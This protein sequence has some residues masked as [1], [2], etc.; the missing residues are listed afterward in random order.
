MVHSL[1]TRLLA[2]TFENEV[3]V[4]FPLGGR[5]AAL[6][7]RPRPSPAWGRGWS[8]VRVVARE[9]ERQR[10]AGLR[11]GAPGA[12]GSQDSPRAH[13]P[14]TVV[15]VVVIII[16]AA[17]VIAIASDERIG[18]GEKGVVEGGVCGDPPRRV[19]REEAA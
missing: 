19:A 15:A 18:A 7:A 3:E 4:A 16:V 17:I 10:P 13:G 11:A 14:G 2:C 8:V 6:E 1:R 5:V 12:A 9:V